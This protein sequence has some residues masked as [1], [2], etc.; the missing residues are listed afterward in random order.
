VPAGQL[1]TGNSV[2]K[3]DGSYGVVDAVAVE[4][5]PQVMYNLTI[6]VAHT[7]FVGDGRWLVHNADPCGALKSYKEQGGHH[8]I[9]ASNVVPATERAGNSIVDNMLTVTD[10]VLESQGVRHLGKD[11]LTSV[12]NRLLREFAES[13]EVNT[14]EKQREIAQ[15]ALM[16][17]GIKEYTAKKW[18]DKAYQQ[19]KQL[20]P[21]G[22]PRTPFGK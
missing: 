19:M 10:D 22:P 7:F 17:A 2:R 20:F 8:I 18:A 13:G 3:A 6:A 9:A 15:K 12:Q 21:K 4:Q 16:Q 14:W 5:R 11:S 1:Q